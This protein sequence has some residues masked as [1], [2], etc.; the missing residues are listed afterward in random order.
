MNH[1]PTTSRSKSLEGGDRNLMADAQ[2]ESVFECNG[3][4]VEGSVSEC[5]A[6][7]L[8]TESGGQGECSSKLKP[9]TE[10]QYQY[11]PA[12]IEVDLENPTSQKLPVIRNVHCLS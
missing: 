12:L 3:P 5:L 8:G 10:P 1:E 2:R 6:S 4:Y 7:D 9:A 11:Q